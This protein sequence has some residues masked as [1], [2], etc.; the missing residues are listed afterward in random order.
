MKIKFIN[1]RVLINNNEKY[2]LEENQVLVSGENIVKIAKS[3]E[4]DADRTIDVKGDVL[5]PGFVNA[6]AHNPM[7][8]LRGIKND[9]D[10]QTWLFDYIIPNEQKLTKEDIYYGEMLGIAESVRAGI[11]CFEENYFEID[12]TYKAIKKAKMRARIG[13]GVSFRGEE[14]QEEYF[15]NFIKLI[16]GNNLVKAVS[17]PHSIYTVPEENMEEFITLAKKHNL[18]VA[19]HLCETLKEVGDCIVKNK[20]T[21]PRYLEDM[22]FMDRGATLYHCVH[23]DK[24]DIQILFDYNANVVTCPSSNLKLASGIAPLH[25]F[26]D[27]GINLAIGT[28]GPASNDSL[29]M[30]KEMFLCATLP[31]ANLKESQVMTIDQILS[32]ATVNGAKALGFEKLGKIEE[33]YKADLILVDV[34][35]L[36]HM[37]QNNLISNLV[38]SAKSS[39]VYLTMVAGNILYENGKFN[40]G[41]DINAITLKAKQIA[42]KFD[43]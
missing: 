8:L 34:N 4:D 36:H 20:V 29:D 15:E 26:L 16:V 30:F 17:Y 14:T 2:S 38:Y 35:G 25:T 21:P 33:G 22:G 6:H 9:V 3:I 28:D 5:M 40:I 1:A 31:K 42:S 12:S 27:K 39:D 32:M 23:M 11:T 43:S 7:T 37:P 24:D 41:E 13:I 18:P 19:T 10:L